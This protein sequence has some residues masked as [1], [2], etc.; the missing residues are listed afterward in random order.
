MGAGGAA[1]HM[2]LRWLQLALLWCC[3]AVVVCWAACGG[4]YCG[5]G[6]SHACVGCRLRNV[7]GIALAARGSSAAMVVG[8]V[9][10]WG[11]YGM[12][13]LQGTHACMQSHADC[14]LAA[15]VDSDRDKPWRALTQCSWPLSVSVADQPSD[16]YHLRLS[17][18][19]LSLLFNSQLMRPECA[20]CRVL[21]M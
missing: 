19:A 3:P 6:G 8:V 1:T 7:G 16:G 21:P 17:A 11:A 5:V 20:A 18:N 10:G 15:A 12:T 13:L 14:R 2:K 4:G 9:G